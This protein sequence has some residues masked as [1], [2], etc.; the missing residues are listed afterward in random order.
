M[1]ERFLFGEKFAAEYHF[2]PWEDF[3]K[4]FKEK[5]LYWDFELYAFDWS[6]E[7][8]ED[9]LVNYDGWNGFAKLKDEEFRILTEIAKGNK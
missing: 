9:L 5:M 8:G 2:L 6:N 7:T 3:A 4:L 1:I